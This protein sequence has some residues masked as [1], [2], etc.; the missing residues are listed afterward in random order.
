MADQFTTP[1]EAD[2]DPSGE[3]HSWRQLTS[4]LL[5]QNVMRSRLFAELLA[6][7][8]KPLY[9]SRDPREAEAPMDTLMAAFGLSASTL[10]A[11][12]IPLERLHSALDQMM[13]DIAAMESAPPESK[14]S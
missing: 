6:L 11:M 10:M 14:A 5:R 8:L 3:F 13:A 1:F 12:G 7:K 9:G 4:W 2:A